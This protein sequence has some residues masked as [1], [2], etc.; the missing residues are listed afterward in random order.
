MAKRI[1]ITQGLK[2]ELNQI[3]GFVQASLSKDNKKISI[4]FPEFTDFIIKINDK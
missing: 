4:Q 1:T 3:C 2:N